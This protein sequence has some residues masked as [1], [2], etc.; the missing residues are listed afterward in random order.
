MTCPLVKSCSSCMK[1]VDGKCS[2][3]ESLNEQICSGEYQ[4]K[5]QIL[6]E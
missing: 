3:S 2:I 6:H 1:F 5:L 4:C